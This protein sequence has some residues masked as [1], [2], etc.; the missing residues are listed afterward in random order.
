[1]PGG[2]AT[3]WLVAPAT[4]ATNDMCAHAYSLSNQVLIALKRRTHARCGF[5]T[6]LK[7]GYAGQRGRALG[8]T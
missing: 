3:L 5:R 4:G 6:W 1:M 2:R 7:L 8:K